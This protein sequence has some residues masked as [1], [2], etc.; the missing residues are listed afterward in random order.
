A[1]YTEWTVAAIEA[2]QTWY[3]DAGG[4]WLTTGWWNSANCLTVLGDFYS[5]DSGSAEEL[6]LSNVF[7]NTFT[8]AQLST[9]SKVRKMIMA[10]GHSLPIV[11]SHSETSQQRSTT[12]SSDVVDR[13]Y[14]GFLNDYYDDEGW[15][16]L[17][18][19]KAYDVTSTAEY[20][21]MAESIFADMEGGVNATCGGGIWWSKDRTYK[22]AIANELYLAVA[23]SLANRASDPGT[24][25][26]IAEEQ[27]EWFLSSGMINS[28]HLIND[29][30][31]INSDGTC[32]NNGAAVW[33]YNQGVILGGLAELYRANGNETLLTEAVAIAEA[34]MQNLTVDGILHDGCEPNCGGDGS[35]FKAGVFM[36]NLQYLQAQV[37]KDEFQTFI[38]D[39]ANS[40]WDNDRNSSNYLGIDWSGPPSAG[41]DPIASTQSSALDALVA[42]V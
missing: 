15:W 10:R 34:A 12:G 30:L 13:G 14:S 17:A 22:N 32:V 9:S 36:R 20:L 4:L 26:A 41:G 21:S 29:G 5:V 25:L 39:N 2:L 37:D 35:Q 24:Y 42:A 18:W 28:D 31:T 1:S 7:S 23:A 33:S 3:D 11:E 38:L 27:W 40:I 16:A 19:I 6:G 8:Q